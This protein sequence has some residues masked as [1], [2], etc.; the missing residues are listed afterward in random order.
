[1][2]DAWMVG[3][4]KRRRT[5]FY[6]V[7]SAATLLSIL[8]VLFYR[9]EPVPIAVVRSVV[10]MP[11]MASAAAAPLLPVAPEPSNVA[12]VEPP[13][14]AEPKLAAGPIAPAS[15]TKRRDVSRPLPVK[16]L[17]SAAAPGRSDKALVN[18]PLGDQK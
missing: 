8:V 5:V 18:D 15:A 14:S 4:T 7:M 13:S 6:A 12:V 11:N 9:R 1:M 10:A 17:A 2:P 16:T 3:A